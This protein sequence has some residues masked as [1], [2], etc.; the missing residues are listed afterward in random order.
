MLTEPVSPGAH[1]G[2]LFFHN[3]GF[4]PMSGHGV[5][6]VTKIALDRGLVMPGGQST[7]IVFDTPAGTVRATADGERVS[8]VNVPAY[9]LH[10]GVPVQLGPRALRADIAF[11]GLFYA[12]VDGEAAGL[13]IDADHAPE[14]SRAGVAIREA[15]ERV[16]A[17]DGTVFTGAPHESGADLRNAVVFADGA[18]ERSPSGTAT[19]A[20]MAVLDAMGLLGDDRPFVHESIAGTRFEGRLT[21]RTLVGEYPALIT[22]IAG[23]AWITGEH[24]F[25]V[26]DRDPLK[27]GLRM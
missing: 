6:G 13:S 22:E 3:S 27:K 11:G 16:Q 15:V 7:T 1:A 12:I 23:S 8:V 26:D 24:T 5:M 4:A 21:G 14:L 19:S 25:V 10:A 20:V 17:V 9:V 18:V 2:V